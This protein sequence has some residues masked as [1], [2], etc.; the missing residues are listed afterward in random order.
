ML[1]NKAF[2]LCNIPSLWDGVFV[3]RIFYQH[4]VPWDAEIMVHRF[5]TKR[6]IPD[7]IKNMDVSRIFFVTSKMSRQGFRRSLIYTW[8]PA[9]VNLFGLFV[10]AELSN[11]QNRPSHLPFS[12]FAILLFSIRTTQ[13]IQGLLVHIFMLH[14][15]IAYV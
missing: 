10:S 6:F 7:G 11:V 1:R 3:L 4:C 14:Y 9:S 2:Y 12:F 8:V 13:I 5:S 15:K